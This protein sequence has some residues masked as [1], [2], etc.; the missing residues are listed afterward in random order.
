LGH[1]LRLHE[2]YK[3]RAAFLFVAIRDAGHP[4][5]ATSPLAGDPDLGATTSAARLR[6]IRKGLGFYKVPF[7]TLLDEDGQV[8]LAYDAYPKRLVIV[9][10]DGLVVFDGGRGSA[11]GPSD[12]NLEDVEQHLRSAL[13]RDPVH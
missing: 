6:L 12:W 7:P 1:L 9:G 2:V 13:P 10:A 4:D 11:G 5:P 3:D 8:E